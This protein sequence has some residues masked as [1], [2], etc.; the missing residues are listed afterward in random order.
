MQVVIKKDGFLR[1]LQRGVAGGGNR[2]VWQRM[3]L[4]GAASG[5]VT[6]RRA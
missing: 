6:G 3:S 1:S 2:N 5:A 4:N